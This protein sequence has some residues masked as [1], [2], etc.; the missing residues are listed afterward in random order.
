M[1]VKDIMTAD[2]TVCTPET[3]LAAAAALMWNGDFGILPVV[4]DGKLVG[5]VTDRDM[6]IAL[7]TRNALASQLRVADVASRAVVTCAPEDDVHLAL[8]TMSKARVRRL[9]VVGRGRRIVG[10]LSMHDAVLEAGAQGALG[11]EDVVE[12]LQAICTPRR[13]APHIAAA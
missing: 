9:P 12:T 8:A 5:V 1:K 4:D 11:T 10:V 13:G 3:T 7:A 6:Y 2:P